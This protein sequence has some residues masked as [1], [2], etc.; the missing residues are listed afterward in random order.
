MR[1][2]ILGLALLSST[3]L[4][5]DAVTMEAVRHVAHGFDHPSVTFHSHTTGTITAALT[6]SG[7]SFRE[8]K[9]VS[10]G[11]D[12]VL[13]LRDLPKGTHACKGSLTLRG[14]DGTEGS[15]PLSIEV[16]VHPAPT[17]SVNEAEI[18]LSAHKLTLRSDRYLNSV[19]LQVYGPNNKAIGSGSAQADG[20]N[21][22]DMEWY[23][24]GEIVKIEIIGT[25]V[26]GIKGKLDLLPWSY[27]IPHEDL[28]FATNKHDIEPSEV[29]K[30]EAAWAELQQV[31]AKYG[32]VVEVQLYVA[33]YTDT[34]GPID[35]NQA[36][37]DRRARSIAQWFRQRGFK[38]PIWSQG[39][40]ESAPAVATGDGVDEARNR[41]AL[42]I[43]A[44]KPPA[45]ST[46]IP[47]SNWSAL[48]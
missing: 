2:V 6:C 29:S 16:G 34:A 1:F 26:H 37:S 18:D 7:M 32:E 3:A 17:L 9:S 45:R 27:N 21:V 4:A 35:A 5:A 41:R 14:D 42:Y 8:A 39:L 43:L 11:D 46:D 13:T 15:M 36:L 19:A 20:R 38:G 10:P 12:L 25:D 24:D 23:S 40:G 48:K 30:L 33:G 47:R 22:V 28:I 44:A 31:V